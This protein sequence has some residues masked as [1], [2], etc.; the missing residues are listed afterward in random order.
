[1]GSAIN[2]LYF[3]QVTPSFDSGKPL[4]NKDNL[5]VITIF[6]VEVFRVISPYLASTVSDFEILLYM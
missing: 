1:M 4:T 2:I 5:Q 6:N 3:W